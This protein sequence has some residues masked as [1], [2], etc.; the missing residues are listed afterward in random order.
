MLDIE[1]NPVNAIVGAQLLSKWPN[2]TTLHRDG[3][4][5]W[6]RPDDLAKARLPDL[7]LLD[8][9]LPTEAGWLC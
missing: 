5:K 8:M 3:G 2:V 4:A 1:S 9:Q 6:H 7:V